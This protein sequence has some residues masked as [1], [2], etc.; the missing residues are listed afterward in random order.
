MKLNCT[1]LN[2]SRAGQIHLEYNFKKRNYSG[3]EAQRHKEMLKDNW[4][5][6][7][8]LCFEILRISYSNKNFVFLLLCA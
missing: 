7:C 1:C 3:I 6:T 2:F 4:N 8:T 5:Y